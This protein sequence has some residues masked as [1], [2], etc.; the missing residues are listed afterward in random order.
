MQAADQVTVDGWGIWPVQRRRVHTNMASVMGGGYAVTG[1]RQWGLQSSFSTEGE[2]GRRGVGKY[3]VCSVGAGDELLVSVASS[4][5]RG[6]EVT[7]SPSM[8]TREL[9]H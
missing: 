2:E 6:R 5:S 1:I 4:V 9:Q 8:T 3:Y 7:A